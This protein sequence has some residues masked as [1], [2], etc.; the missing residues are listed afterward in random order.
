MHLLG[1]IQEGTDR[2]DW[3]ARYPGRQVA[4]EPRLARI[5]PKEHLVIPDLVEQ[6][7]VEGQPQR[8]P[9]FDIQQ[10]LAPPQRQN[11]CFGR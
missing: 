10:G 3:L 11:P 7:V 8:M 9:R 5:Q 2:V 1:R 6:R 4:G